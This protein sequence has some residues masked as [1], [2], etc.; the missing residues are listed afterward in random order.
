MDGPCGDM[1]CLNKCLGEKLP[2]GLLQPSFQ[3]RPMGVYC[4]LVCRLN[5]GGEA[6]VFHA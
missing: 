1:A 6:V 4:S 3:V 5:K 2:E